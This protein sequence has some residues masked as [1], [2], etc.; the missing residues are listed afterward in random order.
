MFIQAIEAV[1]CFEEKVVTTV[2]E[3]NIGSIFG[4]GFAPFKG[5]ALQFI[6][7]FGVKAFVEKATALAD[8][9]GRRFDPPE[10]LKKMAENDDDI[11]KSTQL[12]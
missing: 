9:Y 11:Q 6:N 1:R 7:D 4:W 2:A 10:I 8:K 12:F 5:G 3:A